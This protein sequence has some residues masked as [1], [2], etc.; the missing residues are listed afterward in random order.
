ML[1]KKIKYTNYVDEEKEGTYYFNL[2]KTELAQSKFSDQEGLQKE[3][4]LAIKNKDN[5]KL[6]AILEDIILSSY[7]VVSDDGE[8]FDKSPELS[9]KFRKS[10]AYDVLVDSLL[11]NNGAEFQEFLVGILP[12]DMQSAVK[13]ELKKQQAKTEVTNTV[14]ELTSK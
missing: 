11:A 14:A 1:R 4:D 10:K 9:A 7:G 2:T 12:S 6:W 8:T 13:T 5:V 3:L